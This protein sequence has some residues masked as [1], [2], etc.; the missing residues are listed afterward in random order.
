[1]AFTQLPKDVGHPEL[2]S[3][4][5]FLTD[6]DV[7]P[8]LSHCLFYKEDLEIVKKQHAPSDDPDGPDNSDNH[9]GFCIS[10]GRIKHVNPDGSVEDRE[11]L[12]AFSVTKQDDNSDGAW[13]TRLDEEDDYIAFSCPRYET[14]K[15][16]AQIK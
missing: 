8:H 12:V 5:E 15:N 9:I 3:E 4:F 16:R 6:I 7:P 14:P 10:F 2:Q 1:M 13:E 11:C